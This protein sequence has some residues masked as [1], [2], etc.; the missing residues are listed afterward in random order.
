VF[1][2]EVSAEFLD[3]FLKALF[4]PQMAKIPQIIS[5]YLRNLRNL[6]MI[7]TENKQNKFALPQMCE[8]YQ[9]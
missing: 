4:Y 3:H 5:F 9:N 8:M 7:I 6:W 1:A 2:I